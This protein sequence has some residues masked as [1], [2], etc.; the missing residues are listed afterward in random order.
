MLCDSMRRLVLFL[1]THVCHSQTDEEHN[2]SKRVVV[3]SEGS[4]R[5]FFVPF[6]CRRCACLRWHLFPLY[7]NICI[8]YESVFSRSLY[9][10]SFS[11]RLLSISANIENNKKTTYDFWQIPLVHNFLWQAHPRQ[12]IPV[13]KKT[14]ENSSSHPKM[15]I[16]FPITNFLILIMFH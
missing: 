11:S 2:W 6:L 5:I 8:R 7:S 10:I 12:S 14:A 1:S 13:K 3:L 16:Y 15:Y 4:H 9:W